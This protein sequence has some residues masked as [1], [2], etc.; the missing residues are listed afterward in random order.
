MILTINRPL[1]QGVYIYTPLLLLIWQ[2]N[3]VINS[4]NEAINTKNINS[5]V[6]NVS[7]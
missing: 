4:V 2:I 6:L 5:T 3:S 1:T 7:A